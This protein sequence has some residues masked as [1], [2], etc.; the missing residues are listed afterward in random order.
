[1]KSKDGLTLLI[2][3]TFSDAV[4]LRGANPT[5]ETIFSLATVLKYVTRVRFQFYHHEPD[6]AK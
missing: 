6:T 1:M 4:G 3:C 5:Y 2:N